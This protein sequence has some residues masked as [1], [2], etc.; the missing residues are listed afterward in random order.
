MGLCP[1]I[2]I[3]ILC[4]FHNKKHYK[5]YYVWGLSKDS[6]I[7][8]LAIPPQGD[9]FLSKLKNREEFEGGLKKGKEKGRKEGKKEKSDKIHVK[10][11]L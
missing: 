8:I 9:I 4:F 1:H 6:G 11:P 2:S 5:P 7:S 10:I 3:V